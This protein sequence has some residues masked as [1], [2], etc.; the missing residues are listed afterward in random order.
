MKKFEVELRALQTALEQAQAT[1]TSPELGRLSLKEQLSHR[2]VK[3]Q[4]LKV[5]TLVAWTCMKNTECWQDCLLCFFLFQILA[6]NYSQVNK[7]SNHRMISA[8]RDLKD[9][10]VPVSLPLEGKPST[11]S[12]CSK[13]H[14]TFHRTLLG[15]EASTVSLCNLSYCFTIPIMNNFFLMSDLNVPSFSLKPF[16]LPPCKSPHLSCRLP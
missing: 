9:H 4:G 11:R 10:L 16:V 13:P 2:Q 6:P 3:V 7:E 8:V 5:N 1:L 15:N 12:Y 14:P